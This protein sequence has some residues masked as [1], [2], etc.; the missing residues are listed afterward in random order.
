M[1]Q[2]FALTTATVVGDYLSVAGH[3]ACIQR[4]CL[5]RDAADEKKKTKIV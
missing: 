2:I 4:P 1:G 3:N 5:A